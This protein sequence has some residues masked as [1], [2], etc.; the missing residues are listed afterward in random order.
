MDGRAPAPIFVWKM[1]EKCMKILWENQGGPHWESLP[2][3]G[4]EYKDLVKNRMIIRGFSLQYKDL[5]K[6]IK[7]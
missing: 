3:D 5:L 2:A 1:Y 4:K 7:I 6:N